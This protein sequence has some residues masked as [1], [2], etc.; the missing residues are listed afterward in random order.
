MKYELNQ[1]VQRGHAFAVVDEVDS[2][3]GRRGRARRSSSPA[4]RTNKSDLYNSIDKLLPR[5]TAEDFDLD[6]KQRTVNLTEA[7]NEHIEQLLR[8][9]GAMS[10]EDGSPL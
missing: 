7:G 4:R 3:S 1:M 8:E 6:E 5:L 10:E 2:I 9:S